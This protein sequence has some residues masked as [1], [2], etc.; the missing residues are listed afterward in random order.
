MMNVC[1]IGYGYWGSKLARNIQ[2]SDFFNLKFIVDKNKKN[3]SSA[4]KIYGYATFL[5]NYKKILKTPHIDLVIISTPTK[6]HYTISKQILL[7]K[8]NI[9]VEKPITLNSKQLIL[10]EK[11]AKKN[12]KKIFVDYPF[13]FSGGVKFIKRIIP[14]KYRKGK[15]ISDRGRL[16]V[17]DEYTIPDIILKT[18]P[19]F[20][21][22]RYQN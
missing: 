14:N 21:I 20:K 7:S 17:D 16:L 22:M 13:I 9:L 18:D 8:K 1:L 12:K 19:L 15:R 10:L 4:K 5:N 2:N 3:L 6:T 11:I